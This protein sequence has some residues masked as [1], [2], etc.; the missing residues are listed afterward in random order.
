MQQRRDVQSNVGYFLNRTIRCLYRAFVRFLLPT[1]WYNYRSLSG[2]TMCHI[3]S[4]SVTHITVV[5]GVTPCVIG[6][7]A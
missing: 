1:E 2:V 6:F 4:H 3:V 7:N 5:I